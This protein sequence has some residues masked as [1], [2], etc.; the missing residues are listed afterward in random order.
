MF[1]SQNFCISSSNHYH[2]CCSDL[3]ATDLTQVTKIREKAKKEIRKQSLCDEKVKIS[4]KFE[5]KAVPFMPIQSLYYSLLF[6]S[7]VAMP[8]FIFCWVS[9]MLA[10]DV[11]PQIYRATTEGVIY[12]VLLYHS[13]G[14]RAVIAVMSP[15]ILSF[16]VGF[17]MLWLRLYLF[18]FSDLVR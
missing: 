6:P 11:A 5:T 1:I 13:F 3:P 15:L 4:F 8:S 12:I 7:W 2:E 10:L 9:A 16:P 18:L 14:C 17:F